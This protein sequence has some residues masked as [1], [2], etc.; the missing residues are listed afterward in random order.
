MTSARR[1]WSSSLQ[2]S[3]RGADKERLAG[4][5]SS[6][7]CSSIAAAVV[8]PNEARHIKASR[9]AHRPVRTL[10][11]L[12]P[13]EIDPP[14]FLSNSLKNVTR[15]FK[16][17]FP[18]VALPACPQAEL[19]SA[20]G[21]AGGLYLERACKPSPTLISDA[22]LHV[23]NAA[24]AWWSRANDTGTTAALRKDNRAPSRPTFNSVHAAMCCCS[25]NTER[26]SRPRVSH[27]VYVLR[28]GSVY[29]LPLE[30]RFCFEKKNLGQIKIRDGKENVTGMLLCGTAA[31]CASGCM[32][33][34][35]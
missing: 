25:S 24:R 35:F 9:P 26:R 10:R 20:R 22:S 32:K 5:S 18:R 23:P 16:I 30:A 15:P 33:N 21:W 34:N 28:Q 13:K 14:L 1:E 11:P 19:D 4:I 31:N 8:F 7:T 27:A 17:A 3:A 29:C 12:S 6:S 2:R